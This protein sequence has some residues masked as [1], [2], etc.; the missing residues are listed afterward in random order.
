PELDELC[1][2]CLR[3][4]LSDRLPT[5]LDFQERLAQVTTE[6]AGPGLRWGLAIG[7]AA[8][9]LCGAIALAVSGWFGGGPS[10]DKPVSTVPNPDEVVPGTTDLL[11]QKPRELVFE[12]VD[13]QSSYSYSESRTLAI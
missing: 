2:H 7:G 12:T 3:R 13:P 1:L 4:D 10:Q 11:R 8:I 6:K 5:A 9:L